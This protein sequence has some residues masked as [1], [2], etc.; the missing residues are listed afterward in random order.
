M[1]WKRLRQ[2][3]WFKIL[4]NL[5]V[6]ILSIFVVWMLFFDQNSVLIQL[7]LQRE[8]QKLEEQKEFLQEQINTDKELIETLSDPK[9]L[10]KFA[11]ETYFLKKQN[12]DIYIIEFQDSSKI[13]DR[14]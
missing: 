2:K 10:E 9:E 14:E 8:I 7:E 1:F 6:L 4:S 5:Y 13:K 12:E 11:R 3:K